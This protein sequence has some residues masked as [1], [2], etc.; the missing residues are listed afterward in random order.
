[1]SAKHLGLNE[2]MKWTTPV[3]QS[4]K[5]TI[6]NRVVKGFWQAESALS[7]DVGVLEVG[8]HE[9]AHCFVLK[10]R[11]TKVRDNDALYIQRLRLLDSDSITHRLGRLSRVESDDQ[12]CEVVA[13]TWF[14]LK[15]LGYKQAPLIDLVR[16]ATHSQQVFDFATTRARTHQF[17]D[18][19]DSHYQY[20]T[21][22]ELLFKITGEYR[23]T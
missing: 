22:A 2:F 17:I 8:L 21:T 1:M 19:I 15:L 4:S 11:A 23:W 6:L 14:W 9:A 18:I 12:E 3:R 20:R 16:F 5:V 10:K 13:L 7:G